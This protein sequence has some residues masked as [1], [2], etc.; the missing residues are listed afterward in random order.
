MKY[1]TLLTDTEREYYKESINKMFVICPDE[2]SRK[3]PEAN[4]QQA[5]VVHVVEELSK[6]NKN[7]DLLCVGSYEDTAND[8]LKYLGYNILDIDPVIN[9]S[10][11]EFINLTSDTFDIIFSTS[12]IEHVKEDDVFLDH[13]CSL[14]N[15]GGIGILTMD[16]NNSYYPGMEVP[17]TVVRQ[18][19]KKDLEIRLIKILDK[20]NCKLVD[21][22]DWN[23]E[24]DFI[25]GKFLYSFATFV[26]K[27]EK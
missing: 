7:L 5:F 2:M 8:Y 21:E 25:L 20:Y 19:T 4:V 17:D 14:L 1:N 15:K 12:V 6:Y 13:I 11:E 18:Y 10:L 24:P 27:K 26:F 3:I 9:Y 22:P 23:G 16:F